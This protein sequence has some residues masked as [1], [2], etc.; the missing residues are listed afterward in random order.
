M[1]GIIGIV[2]NHEVQDRLIASLKR[3]EYRGYDSAGIAIVEHSKIELRKV[4]GK[5]D[6]LAKVLKSAPISGL[7]G[8]G[9]TRWA[10][11]GEPAI[12]N[13]HP[14]STQRIA[15]VHNG[16]IENY[17]EVKQELVV[18]G[19]QFASQTDTE[20][21]AN[22]IDYYLSTGLSE[23]NTVQTALKKLH[24]AFSIAVLFAHNQDLLIGARKGAPLV[25]GIGQSEMYLGSDAL[26]LSNLTSQIVHLQDN[27]IAIITRNTYEIITTN[28]HPV[29]RE[30]I[31]AAN[32]NFTFDKGNYTTFM[33]KEI[34]EQPIIILE[35]FNKYFDYSTKSF[36]FEKLGL[37]FSKYKRFYIVACGTAYHAAAIAKYLIEKFA[38]VPVEIDIASEFRYRNPI[39]MKDSLAILISQSGETADTLAALQYIKTQDI[40]TVAIVN[41]VESTIALSADYILPLYVGPEIGVASTKAFSGQLTVLVALCLAIANNNHDISDVDFARYVASFMDLP[42]KIEEILA[43]DSMIQTIANNIKIA[44][45][46]LYIGRGVSSI[47]ALEGALKIKELSY[48]HAEGLAAGELKHGPIALIDQDLPVIVVAPSDDLSSKTLSNVHEVKT[49]L[50]NIIVFTDSQGAPQFE[51]LT[52]KVIQLPSSNAFTAPI[53]YTIPLQLLAYHTAL[54]LG[55]DIDQPRNLAKSVTVE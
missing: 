52:D 7:T 3:L 35:T 20:V 29:Q 10:T 53:L 24:G 6:Q 17:Q 42:G 30:S 45:S 2:G 9:H 16:I 54:A 38:K 32:N 27:E 8:I 25:I 1:C 46:I 44:N 26:G 12:K 19:Y 15:L 34:H 40:Q 51:K 4:V 18:Q 14:F 49:R 43:L 22:L 28:N 48:I 41:N 39:L 21:I 23:I 37:D 5:I 33:L 11:H 47:V 50:G 31:E 13:A 36:H 55:K